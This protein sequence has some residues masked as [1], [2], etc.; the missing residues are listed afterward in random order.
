MSLQVRTHRIDRV[1]LVALPGNKLPQR[2]GST[3]QTRVVQHGEMIVTEV[4]LGAAG[5]DKPLALRGLRRHGHEGVQG[6]DVGRRNGEPQ[7][8]LDVVG[9]T[10]NA[11]TQ[12]DGHAIV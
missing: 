11:W 12:F 6:G 2:S 8:S 5:C 7:R 3:E 10:V 9:A 1:Q 4:P